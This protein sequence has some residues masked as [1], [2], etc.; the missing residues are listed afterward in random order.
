MIPS[1]F[2]WVQWL[3]VNTFKSN[4]KAVMNSNEITGATSVLKLNIDSDFGNMSG[5]H[6]RGISHM[7]REQTCHGHHMDSI[8]KRGWGIFVEKL[9]ESLYPKCS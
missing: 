6:N 7:S 5:D 4:K 8:W 1:Q 3:K 2:S 9:N